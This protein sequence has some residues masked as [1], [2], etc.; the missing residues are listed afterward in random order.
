LIGVIVVGCAV[1]VIL[2]IL[3]VYFFRRARRN[4]FS[5]DSARPGTE[6]RVATLELEL[7]ELKKTVPNLQSK[8]SELETTVPDLQNKLVELE[9]GNAARNRIASDWSIS[10]PP[11]TTHPH[12]PEGGAEP[13]NNPSG[14]RTGD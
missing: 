10:P 11:T 4:G 6:N 3:S 12:I 2:I 8:L 9:A 13:G 14:S 5:D 7:R 1:A